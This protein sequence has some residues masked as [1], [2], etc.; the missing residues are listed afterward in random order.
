MYSRSDI[1]VPLE[2]YVCR[3]VIE[4]YLYKDQPFNRLRHTLITSAIV[5]SAM[6]SKLDAPEATAQD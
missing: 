2:N 5:F 1:T 4:D 6:L 3:E